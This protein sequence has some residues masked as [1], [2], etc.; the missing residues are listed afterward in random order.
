MG[1]Y[2]IGISRLVGAIIESSHDENGIIWPE[3]V[4]PFTVG[5]VN[6]KSKDTEAI[7]VCENIYNTLNQAGIEV[8]YDDKDDSPGA[9]FSRMDLIGLPKQII[10]GNNSLKDQMIEIKDRKTSHTEKIK[11]RDLASKLITSK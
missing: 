7:T 3:A 6:L 10:Y 1:S 2:G 4:A 5:L 11:I 9:K 8:L